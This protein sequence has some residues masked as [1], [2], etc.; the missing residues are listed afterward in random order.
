[1][2][3]QHGNGIQP[4]S[5]HDIDTASL[6]SLYPH[7]S[8]YLWIDKQQ[9]TAQAIVALEFIADSSQPWFKSQR[10]SPQ[11]HPAT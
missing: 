1:M 10:L 4:Y 8:D 2:A 11:I 3:N 5:D 7:I 9:P 6:A